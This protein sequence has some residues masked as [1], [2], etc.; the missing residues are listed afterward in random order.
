MSFSNGKRPCAFEFNK[1]RIEISKILSPLKN[2]AY[3]LTRYHRVLAVE[4][5]LCA[6]RGSAPTMPGACREIRDASIA[7]CNAL[8]SPEPVRE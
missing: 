6:L 4:A 2:A 1:L 5:H 8:G 3:P 7:S